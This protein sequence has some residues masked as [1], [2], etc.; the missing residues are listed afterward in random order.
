[1]P[2]GMAGGMLLD[3]CLFHCPSHCFLDGRSRNMVALA[4]PGTGILPSLFRWKQV[5][6]S[7]LFICI[8][9]FFIQCFWQYYLS[10]SFSLIPLVYIALFLD[11]FFLLVFS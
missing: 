10:P 4:A 8:G 11:L 7:E 6:P 5:L 3:I 1:M 2:K 9:I